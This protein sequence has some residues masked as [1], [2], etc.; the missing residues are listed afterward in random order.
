MKKFLEISEIVF[1][2]FSLTFFTGGFGIGATT[3]S[4]GLIPDSVLTIIRYFIWITASAIICFNWKKALLT[5]SRDKVL[6]IFT[7]IVLISFIWSDYKMSTLLDSREVW[8]MTSFGLYFA[9]RFSLRE[10]V[11]LIALTFGIGA[12]LSTIFALGLPSIGKHGA[13]HPG[14]WK[15]IYDYKNTL[16]SMMVMSAFAF[17]LLPINRS[18][19]RL[20]KWLGFSLSI[21]LI[22]LS[23][24]GS[25]LIIFS[26]IILVFLFFRRFKWQGKISVLFLDIFILLFG[27]VATFLFMNWVTIVTDFGKDPTFT[28]RTPL[29]NYIISKLQENPWLGYGRG[30]FWKPGSQYAVQA[31]E[32]V[33]SNFVAPHGH[34]GFLDLG[35]DVGLV[36]FSLFFVSL[37]TAFVW[38]LKRA[39]ATKKSEDIWPLF[40]LLFLVMNNMTES[41][42]LRITNVYWVLYVT[43]VLTVKQRRQFGN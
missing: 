25:S 29:W 13:D 32:S 30:A 27:C 34:N 35:L 14:A 8:Q 16:G 24:S 5:A 17:L 15:G 38:A 3:T 1:V 40:F 43:V 6:W 4:S 41:Y 11:K 20:Y 9:T 19:N 12:L 42:L 37:I 33:A 39:Y 23:Y 2:V 7:A 22:L 18:E 28:G 26:L 31:G 36:G 21:V 10:Q